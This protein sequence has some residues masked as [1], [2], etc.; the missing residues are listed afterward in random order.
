M[1]SKHQHEF[2]RLPPTKMALDQKVLRAHY[3]ALTRKSAHIVTHIARPIR[4]WLDV[5][6][7]PI[8]TKNPPVPG[9]VDELSLCRCK[10]GCT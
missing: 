2:D 3:T 8:M 6:Y 7:H 9:T 10:T 5:K 1:F 4:T